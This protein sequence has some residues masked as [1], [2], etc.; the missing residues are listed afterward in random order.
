[1]SDDTEK[2]FTILAARVMVID[3]L[4]TLMLT[5]NLLRLED[6]DEAFANFKHAVYREMASLPDAPPVIRETGMEFVEGIFRRVSEALRENWL[7][8]EGGAP[9]RQ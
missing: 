4:L 9:G 1:M 8:G 2:L 7:S 6:T 3:R 5:A